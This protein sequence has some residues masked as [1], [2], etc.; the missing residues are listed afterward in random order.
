MIAT[1]TPP[2]IAVN[3]DTT[4]L[5]G[6]WLAHV[7]GRLVATMRADGIDEPLAQPVTLAA[8]LYDLFTLA[9]APVPTEIQNHIG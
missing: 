2:L 7:A 8:V 1:T 4:L 9:G 5:A 6:G 3:H